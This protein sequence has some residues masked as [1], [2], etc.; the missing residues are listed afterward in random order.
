MR[1]LR[2]RVLLTIVAVSAVTLGAVG[3]FST[4]TSTLELERFASLAPSSDPEA[5]GSSLQAGYDRGGSE[6]AFSATVRALSARFHRRIIVVGLH[7]S[8][9]A[10]SDPDLGAMTAT[11]SGGGAVELRGRSSDGSTAVVVLRGPAATLRDRHG[12]PAA[13]AYVLPVPGPQDAAI[14]AGVERSIWIA[15]ALAVALAALAASLLSSR[16]LG[17]VEALTHAAERLAR[18][19]L[20]ARVQPVGDD[21]IG[22]LGRSFNAMADALARLERARKELVAD[23]AHELRTPLTHLRGRIEAMQDGRL[24][25]TSDVLASVENDVAVLTRLVGDLQ[26]LSL[27]DAGRLRLSPAVVSVAELV[28]TAV[29]LGGGTAVELR[30]DDRLPAAIGDPARVRQILQNMLSNAAAH[31][32][33]GSSVTVWARPLDGAVAVTVR[34][35]GERLEPEELA[36]IFE[37]FYRTDRSRSR[38]TGGAGLGLAIV[39]QLV[40]ASGGRVWAESTADPAGVAVTFTLP[41][42]AGGTSQPA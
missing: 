30:V 2:L 31:A 39:K 5:I 38:A 14:A 18:G 21:E 1:S 27:A 37:R 34:N 4:R 24:A 7:G 13:Y 15:V 26:D 42:V 16:I 35:V 22:S 6:S 10:A 36:A 17:P 32:L 25:P 28:R 11:V 41:A 40:E 20:H 19:D 8:I 23:I 29:N 12:A 9:V 33:P 3:L